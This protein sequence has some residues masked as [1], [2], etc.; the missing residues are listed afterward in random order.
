MYP[1]LYFAIKDL[2]GVEINGLK[3][4][5]SFGFFVAISFL[6][7]AW[8]LASELKRKQ[9]LGLLTFTTETITVGAPASLL[10]LL[11]NAFLGFLLG[12]KIIGAFITEGALENP[13]AFILSLQGNAPMGIVMAI[14]F[15]G[16]KWW[17]KEKAKL[18]VP[19][20]KT[21]RIWPSDRVGDMVIYAA[22][23]GFLGAK[24]FHNLENLDELRADPW[25]SLFGFS[26]LTF[27]G[28]LICAGTA[29]IFYAR[30]HQIK[31]IHL[32]DAFAPTMMLAYGLG[33][34]GCQVAGDGDWGIVNT[35]P[36]PFSWIPDWAWSY[37]YPNN[38]ISEGVPIPG[39]EGMYCNQ[40]PLPVYP[41]PLYEILMCLVLF[42]VLWSFRKKIQL[43]GLMAGIYCIMN[44][45]ERFLIEKIRVNTKYDFGSFHPTQ[46]ELISSLFII[47]GI[48]LCYFALKKK[49][50]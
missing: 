6:A 35:N 45:V 25:G 34:V 28:G 1:N 3:I 18:K 10:E 46:A 11:T 42:L 7:S 38:V 39:C 24:I 14:L 37:T 43:P 15:G 49:F 27:Y 22:L 36:K 19:E 4:I 2:F 48:I 41:T 30:K 12:Y 5:N 21:L 23:F 50:K 13:Q 26:G 44:G 20:T 33:R 29:I 47:T 17:E 9:K 8:I 32:A 16:L 31:I 40:L